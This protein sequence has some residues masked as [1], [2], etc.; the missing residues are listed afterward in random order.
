[1]A[2]DPSKDLH[3]GFEMSKI[4]ISPSKEVPQKT[5]KFKKNLKN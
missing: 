5:T 2:L 4:K 1:V 3:L